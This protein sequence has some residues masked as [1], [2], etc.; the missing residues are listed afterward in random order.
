MSPHRIDR[1]RT[2]RPAKSALA[3]ALA[4]CLM[5]SAP[6]FAQSTAA[7]LRGHATA[8]S[9]VTATNVASG[10]VR[11]TQAGSDGSYTLVGLEPGTYRVEAGGAA[12]T[13]TLSVAATSNLDLAGTTATGPTANLGTITVTGVALADVKTSEVG[14]V[15]SL[16]QI[17][18]TPQL[19]R[20]FLEFADTVPGMVFSQ[21]S[22]GKTSLRGG[23]QN[24]SST[25]VYIDGVGQ[26]SYVKEGGVSG[27]F[28][29]LGNPFAQL[30]IGEYKV[31]TSNYKAEYG[32]ISSA[33][34]TAV[35]K[36]GTNEFH[37]ELFYRYTDHDMRARTLGEIQ[38]GR[39]KADDQPNK[40]YGFAIGGPIMKDRAHFFFTYEAKRFDT[41]ATVVPGVSLPAGRLPADI[42]AQYGPTSKPFEEDL[43][44]G[45]IDWEL[46]DDDRLEFSGQYRD[47]HQLDNIGGVNTPD[48][49]IDVVNTDKRFNARWQHS[50]ENWFNEVLATHEDSKYAPTP[51]TFGIGTIYTY[52]PNNDATIIQAGGADPRAGQNKSQKGWSIEDNFTLYNLGANDNHTV[53]MGIRYKAIDLHAEDALNV[54]PQFFYSVNAST[55]DTTPWKAVFSKPVSGLGGLSQSADSNAKQWGLFLQDDW[56]VNDKLILNLGVRWDY[57]ENP[58]YLD[59]V[60]PA[61][62]V[63]ALN[64]QDPNGPVGQTYAQ[65]LANGGIDV[66]DYISTGSNRKGFKG[67]IQPR[68]G[69]SYDIDADE[70]HVIHG[71]IGRAY[72]RDLYDYLQLEITKTAFPQFTVYFQD[73]NNGNA[74]RGTPCFAFNPSLLNQEALQALVN[75][76]NGGEVDMLNND[77]KAPYSDQFSL[78]I[79]NR[80]G[81]WQTDVTVQRVLSHD[82]FAFTLGN[83]YPNGDFFRNGGQ[84]WGNGV[85][86]FGAL[87]VGNNGIETKITQL[88]LSAVKPYTPESHWS[89]SFAYTYTT[90]EQNRDINEHYSFDGA[91]IGD[92][93]FI[94]TN[95]APRHRIVAAGSYD[96]WWGI[97]I[98]AKLTLATPT[99]VNGFLC[100]PPTQPDM[101]FC[102][103]TAD[104]PSGYGK[105][106]IGGGMWAYRSLDL[107]ATKDFKLFGDTS[108]FV[109][110]DVLNVLNFRNRSTLDQGTINGE[111]KTRYNPTGDFTGVPRT[112]KVEVGFKF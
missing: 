24:N 45:K 95:A 17:E 30:A 83:R 91:T 41:P 10:A 77:L 70:R 69:F 34:V 112:V 12:Q 50:A 82:G 48:H 67:G 88:L 42:E 104:M 64:S 7:T 89:A 5:A 78:G 85:P 14:R 6:V 16:Q 111:F 80:I 99:A 90:G 9:A 47:E 75:A 87:I 73:P 62:V 65:S 110:L 44:F 71:G 3:V 106:L 61:N 93:P 51:I 103:P 2:A 86:G 36:S 8:G 52:R 49:G 26:K 56:E 20:N 63:A 54:N 109:R 101:G 11:R 81:D 22:S 21:D 4:T 79:S 100:Q 94:T 28:S 31:I 96:G 97:N 92:Y 33:A 107:Q 25:N 59:F 53:K 43:Y 76:G 60:T 46:T 32:Q 39:D 35:T 40:D 23:G 18:T 37:G 55:V 74:C 13:V 68:L 98:G 105:F 27:Q 84:P 29:S 1:R 72:D 19:T 102:V 15:V 58:S 57:E 108:A 38:P 66:N